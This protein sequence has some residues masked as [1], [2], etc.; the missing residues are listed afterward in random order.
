MFVVAIFTS[1]TLASPA[2]TAEGSDFPD[3]LFERAEQGIAKPPIRPEPRGFC[4]LFLAL[5][6]TQ[7]GQLTIVSTRKMRSRLMPR[8]C[9]WKA[10]RPARRNHATGS[11]ASVA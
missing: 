6:L 5:L 2:Q 1:L 10:A 3:M 11:A 4:I 8:P 7:P 9:S